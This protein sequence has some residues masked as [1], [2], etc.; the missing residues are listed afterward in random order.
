MGK[1]ATCCVLTEQFPSSS[2]ARLSPECPEMG[3]I[4]GRAKPSLQD[5]RMWLAFVRLE[6]ETS[7]KIKKKKKTK[8][9]LFSSLT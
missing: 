9:F 1:E 7:M 8:N 5:L 2:S 3:G 4:A 6:F